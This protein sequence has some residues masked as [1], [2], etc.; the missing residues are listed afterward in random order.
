MPV[1]GRVGMEM[2]PHWG[3]SAAGSPLVWTGWRQAS[4]ATRWYGQAGDKPRCPQG[5]R[6]SACSLLS[7]VL[8]GDW[9]GGPSQYGT[10][11]PSLRLSEPPASSRKRRMQSP[12]PQSRA[13]GYGKPL[14]GFS[15]HS[16]QQSR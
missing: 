8:Q 13:P 6:L 7:T 5:V 9:E 1:G 16:T 3:R 15:F 12:C 11:G 4:Q 10:V 2:C 14:G